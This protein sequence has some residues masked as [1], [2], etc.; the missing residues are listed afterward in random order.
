[1]QRFLKRR[2]CWPDFGVL[3]VSA[4]RQPGKAAPARRRELDIAKFGEQMARVEAVAPAGVIE[5]GHPI[6]VLIQ[7]LAYSYALA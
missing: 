6:E 1:M 4:P 7:A 2:L 5:R 3:R